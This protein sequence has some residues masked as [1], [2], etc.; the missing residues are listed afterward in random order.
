MDGAPYHKGKIEGGINLAEHNKI[1]VPNQKLYP[2]ERK[3]DQRSLVQIAADLGIDSVAL[4]RDGKRVTVQRANF[5]KG[6]AKSG[7]TTEELRSGMTQWIL[8]SA[9]HKHLLD[10][11]GTHLQTRRV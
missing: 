5:N 6:T 1:Q 8:K 11:A 4:M 7:L 10:G 2:P 3:A 9:D